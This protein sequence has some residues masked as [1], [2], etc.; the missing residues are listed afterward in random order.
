VHAKLTHWQIA[1]LIRGPAPRRRVTEIS[2][3]QGKR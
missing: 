3:D 1:I 2:G